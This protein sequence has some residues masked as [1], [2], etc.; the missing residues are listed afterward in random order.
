[1]ATADEIRT[2]MRERV[3]AHHRQVAQSTAARAVGVLADV[4]RAYERAS[5][6]CTLS[7]DDVESLLAEVAP[8]LA[9]LTEV[10]PS[11]PSRVEPAREA[12]AAE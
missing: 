7:R 4:L 10:A 6:Y 5:F 2:E 11:L 1:M 9:L 8:Y 12:E 3:Q